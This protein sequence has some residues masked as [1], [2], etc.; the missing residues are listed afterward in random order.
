MALINFISSMIQSDF[1]NHQTDRGLSHGQIVYG[2]V[3]KIYPDQRAEVQIG[4]KHLTAKLETGLVLGGKYWFQ[5]DQKESGIHLK[6]ISSNEGKN[7]GQLLNSLMKEFNLPETKENLSLLRFF[8]KEDLPF[9]KQFFQASSQFLKE[10]AYRDESFKLIKLASLKGE[11]PTG[12][13]AGSLLLNEWLPLLKSGGLSDK[14]FLTA[15]YMAEKNLPPSKHIFSALISLQDGESA[16]K[17][18]M[19]LLAALEK[20]PLT[21]NGKALYEGLKDWLQGERKGE[22]GSSKM[23]SRLFHDSLGKLGMDFENDMIRFLSGRGSLQENGMDGLKPLLLRFLQ[24]DVSVTA[25]DASVRLLNK[26]TGMQ[27]LSSDSPL[28][29]QYF[30]QIPLTFID[31]IGEMGIRWEGRK[32]ENGQIDPDYC[33]ILFYLELDILDEVVVDMQIQN[34]VI[35]IAVSSEQDIQPFAHPYI[36]ELKSNLAKMNYQLSAI[37]FIKSNELQEKKKNFPVPN[38]F[39]GYGGVDIR[40]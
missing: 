23:I 30:F 31:K 4:D 40:I 18:G 2:T 32:K 37:K 28:V 38:Q 24:E 10:T 36:N 16:V 29:Q 1:S 3:T 33:R 25:R 7:P 34:R 13:G 8:I 9:T 12:T 17:E 5:V 19:K 35:T 11:G 27:I 39:S 14:A 21:I 20:E 26:I 6:V 15:I 22:I